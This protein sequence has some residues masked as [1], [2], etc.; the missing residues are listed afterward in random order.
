[1]ARPENISDVE[2]R[3]IQIATVEVAEL[4][5]LPA[6]MKHYVALVETVQKMGGEVK[7]NYSSVQILIPKD[8]D[9]LKSQLESEQR[10][11]DSN[12]ERYEKALRGEVIPSYSEYSVTEWAKR[13][14]MAEPVFA[15][16]DDGLGALSPD[17]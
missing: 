4:T 11:W 8:R 6:L 13:E 1:M 12:W 9:Q 3:S 16:E 17:A 2:N 14:G 10:Q 7:K 15:K 5:A